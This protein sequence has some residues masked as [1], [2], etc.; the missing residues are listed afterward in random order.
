MHE[1]LENFISKE[2][3]LVWKFYQ[4]HFKIM[5]VDNISYWLLNQIVWVIWSINQ[6]IEWNC[7]SLINLWQLSS[8]FLLLIVYWGAIGYYKILHRLFKRQIILYLLLIF[9]WI[10]VEF[11]RSKFINMV[12]FTSCWL[13]NIIFRDYSCRRP[14]KLCGRSVK[15]IH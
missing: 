5:P 3:A 10:K 1:R 11:L 9:I 13:N 2:V 12:I 6:R 4:W 8:P 14:L 15:I 7:G